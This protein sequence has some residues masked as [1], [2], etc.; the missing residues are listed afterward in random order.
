MAEYM[1]ERAL[2][3]SRASEMGMDGVPA[4]GRVAGCGGAKPPARKDMSERALRVCRASGVG[5]DG[6]PASERA[7]GCGGAKP[8]ARKTES[9]HG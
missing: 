4:S 5:M 8:P 2:R 3:A 1:S 7:G 6:V 9:H